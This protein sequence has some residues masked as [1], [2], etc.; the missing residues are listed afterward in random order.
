[1]TWQ[2]NVLVV[3][4]QTAGS[5]ELTEA[6]RKRA[7]QG[8][9]TFTLLIPMGAHAKERLDAAVAKMRAAGVEVKG[10]VGIDANPFFALAEVWDPK[11]FDEVVV[12]TF[13]TGVSHWL[14]VDL[15]QRIARLT[16]APVEHVVA[17][18]D[19]QVT[20]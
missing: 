11:V 18:S 3:A 2:T 16:N 15:P 17:Q 6:L 4:N 9:T 19:R 7:E 10:Q 1:L 20:A 13:A 14:N 5:D 8:E 12:S